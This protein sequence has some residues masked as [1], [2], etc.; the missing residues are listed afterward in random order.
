MV[1]LGAG[2]APADVLTVSGQITQSTDDGTGPAMNNPSL[3]NIHDLDAYAV[4]L[5]FMSSI[6]GQ[7]M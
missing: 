4:T 1:C 7:G 5:A 3:N 6:T 2:N